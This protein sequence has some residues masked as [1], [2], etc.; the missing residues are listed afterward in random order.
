MESLSEFISNLLSP[1]GP[2][3]SSPGFLQFL[4]AL[5]IA[6]LGGVLSSLT[7]CVYP[8]IPITISAMGGTASQDREARGHRWRD[9]A[10]RALVYVS[11]MSFVYAFLGVV[12]GLTGKVFGTLTQSGGWYLGLGVVYG[13]GALV[14]LNIIP[15]DPLAWWDRLARPFK[16]SS[17]PTHAPTAH[18]EVTL[19][20][21]FTLGA[22]SGFIASPCTTP[23]LTAILAFIANTQ[24]VGLGLVLMLGFSLG[25]GTLLLGI[26][27]FT[28]AFQFL[29]R[30][31]GWMEK[32]KL[33][34][35][36]LLLAVSHY[37][38][39]QAGNLWQAR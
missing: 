10:V 15:F 31:G 1:S 29:P 33:L 18:R 8:M 30:S 34:S 12:A 16:K 37:M 28:G 4:G 6:Y 32:V 11:G 35:G 19:L 2:S 25:I 7:P 23:V 17:H 26:A 39:F 38:V 36:L 13:L 5:S 20:G 14:M 3:G 9:L 24:S 22:S 27:F 21:A